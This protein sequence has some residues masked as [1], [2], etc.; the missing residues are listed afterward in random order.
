[1]AIRFLPCFSPEASRVFIALP[2]LAAAALAVSSRRAS[3]LII[4]PLPSTDKISGVV[5]VQGA[6][7]RAS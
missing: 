4:M 7:T 5:S 2:P 6:G 3:G 1:M